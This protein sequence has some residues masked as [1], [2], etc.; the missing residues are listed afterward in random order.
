MLTFLGNLD[1]ALKKL[2]LGFGDGAN[3]LS[4]N[5]HAPVGYTAPTQVQ[6]TPAVF[7]RENTL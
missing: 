4:F 3:V 6:G 5:D 2:D 1:N 7:T